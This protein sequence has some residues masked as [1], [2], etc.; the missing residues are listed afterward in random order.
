VETINNP[1]RIE[2]LSCPLVE[3]LLGDGVHTGWLDKLSYQTFRSSAPGLLSRDQRDHRGEE[4]SGIAG[5]GA[6]REGGSQSEVHGRAQALTPLEGGFLNASVL[7][8][9]RGGVLS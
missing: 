2:C 5:W 8:Y 4:A 9:E 7:I 1:A 6:W 3:F